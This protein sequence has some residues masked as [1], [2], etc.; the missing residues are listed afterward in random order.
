[1]MR[2]STKPIET[3]FE[4][5]WKPEGYDGDPGHVTFRQATVGDQEAFEKKFG[6]NK[7]IYNPVEGAFERHWDWVPTE[8]LRMQV[9][10]TMSACDLEDE[11]GKALFEFKEVDGV[12]RLAGTES[13][14]AKAWGAFP[15][16]LA[17]EFEQ[18]ML[19]ANPQWDF[20]NTGEA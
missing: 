17:D 2:I 5:E 18:K 1:M 10:L 12:N 13:K 14:F 9:Y 3:E 7:Q 11:E 8:R 6:H 20:R 4:L 16:E 15:G 19:D